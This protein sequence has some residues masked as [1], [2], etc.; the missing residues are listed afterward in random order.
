VYDE[1]FSFRLIINYA[2]S[3]SMIKWG[4][5]HLKQDGLC[6]G[7]GLHFQ[8]SRIQIYANSYKY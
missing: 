2:W 3:F 8:N 5:E 6:G 4:S 1:A 7:G